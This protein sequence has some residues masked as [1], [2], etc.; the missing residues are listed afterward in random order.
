MKNTFKERLGGFFRTYTIVVVLVAVL[1]LFS[2]VLGDRFTNSTNILNVIRS[3]SMVGLI[4]CGYSFVMISGGCDISTGWQMNLAM[5][6][7]AKLMVDHGVAPVIA[8]LCGMLAC[9]LCQILN[10]YIGVKLNLHGFLV[11]LATMNIF[12]GLT[13]LYTGA[14]TTIGLPE[15]FNWAGQGNLVGTVPVA[16][17]ILLVCTII[18]HVVLNK[19]TFG[20]YVFAIGGNAEAARLSGINVNKQRIL[21]ACWCGVFVGIAGWVMLSRMNTGYPSAATGYEFK[22]IL[23]CCVGGLSFSGGIGKILGVFCGAVVI[24][25]LSN[26]LTLLGVSEYWQYNINGVLMLGAVA[27]DQIIQA[28]AIRHAKLAQAKTQAAAAANS[29]ISCAER[30]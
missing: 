3:V 13:M 2:I 9:V 1:L 12:Q 6:I 24:G 26:G 29:E 16:V 25:V 11:S 8:V 20:R 5:S 10:A 19:T 27:F 17:V 22:A 15:G 4:C 28:S 18:A 23:A 7:M 21:I 14:Q 30:Q